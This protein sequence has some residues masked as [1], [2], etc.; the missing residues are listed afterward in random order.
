MI[1]NDKLKEIWLY[2]Q[3]KTLSAEYELTKSAGIDINRITNGASVTQSRE[4]SIPGVFA[5]GNVLH[6]HDLVDYVS[7]EAEIAGKNAAL[8]IN[9]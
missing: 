4:T 9:G 1:K 7:E 8:Y 6:V 2:E 3:D 5:C